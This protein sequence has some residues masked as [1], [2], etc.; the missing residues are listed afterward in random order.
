MFKFVGF[1][2][3]SL[4]LSSCSADNDSIPRVTP[5]LIEKVTTDSHKNALI[6]QIN[7][8]FNQG[9]AIVGAIPS[10]T[11]IDSISISHDLKD[12]CQWRFIQLNTLSCDLKT[13]LMY[14]A[15]YHIT[16]DSTFNALGHSLSQTFNKIIATQAPI[17]NLHRIPNGDKLSIS[18]YIENFE[19]IDIPSLTLERYL[20]LKSPT[21][22]FYPVSVNKEKRYNRERLKITI[23]DLPEFKEDGRYEFVLPVGFQA[24]KKQ[25][26]LT[27]EYIV[28]SFRH[29]NQLTFYG[30]SCLLSSYPFEYKTIVINDQGVL[31]CAPERI[32]LVFSSKF[33]QIEGI[34]SS[35][36]L[37]WIKGK[38]MSFQHLRYRGDDLH[39][40]IEF[41]GNTEYE[42]D[43]TKLKN[44]QGNIKKPQI[45]IFK[46]QSSTPLWG[47]TDFNETVVESQF[48]ALPQLVR[49][50]VSQLTQETTPINTSQELL[51]F[52]NKKS[53][54]IATTE[55]LIE[56]PN[57]K[58]KLTKQPIP[59][60]QKLKSLSGL[61]HIKLT[62]SSNTPIRQ[63]KGVISKSDSF[64]ANSAAFNMAIWHQQ[65][66]MIQLIDWDGNFVESGDITLVCK[67]QESPLFLGKTESNG[68]LWIKDKAWQKIYSDFR[69][70]ECW[71]WAEKGT[72]TAAIEIPAVNLKLSDSIKAMAWSTQPIYQRGDLV[73]IGFI[74]RKRT[75][76]G[77]TPLTSLKNY[78][79]EL[80]DP[81]GSSIPIILSTP[82]DMGFT[83]GSYQLTNDMPQGKY[84]F[85]L[86]D[87][88]LGRISNV[89]EFIV[90]EFIAPEF[91]HS[92]KAPSKL[93]IDKPIEISI[94][95]KRMN[96]VAL[97]SA[98]ANI[99]FNISRNYSSPLNWP[100]D[101]DFDTWEDFNKNKN[102]LEEGSS[103]S[104]S[105]DIQGK[106]IVNL[107]DYQSTIPYGRMTINSEIIAD[108]GAT[109]TASTSRPYFAR[110]HYIGTKYNTEKQQLE[111]IAIDSQ[112]N[113]INDINV[114]VNI[115]LPNHKDKTVTKITSCQFDTLPAHCKVKDGD[116]PLTVNISSGDD[117]YQWYR[118]ID[119]KQ[120]DELSIIDV[121]NTLE[122]T[123]VDKEIISDEEFNV[124]LTSPFN[125]IATFIINGD[126]IKK[127]WQQPVKKGAN[128]I[129][130]KADKS[131]LPSIRLFAALSVSR[132]VANAAIKQQLSML[133]Q[134]NELRPEVRNNKIYALGSQRLLTDDIVIYSSPTTISPQVKLSVSQDTV[135]A[136]QTVNLT[137]NSEQNSQAQLW[138]VNDALLALTD[139]KLNRYNFNEIIKRHGYN[140][141]YMSY[142]ALSEH[143]VIDAQLGLTS[144]DGDITANQ[145]FRFKEESGM[146]FDI[147]GVS[148]GDVSAMPP[149]PLLKPKDKYQLADSRLLALVDLKKGESQ[150]LNIELPQL[151]GRWKVVALTA[152]NKSASISTIDI[153]TT[154][155]VEYFIDAP[156]HLYSEDVSQLAVT[157]INQS[158]NE[159]T[160]TLILWSDDKPLTTLDVHLKLKQQKRL[161]I[162][163][164]NLPVGKHILRLTSNR[165]ANYVNYHEINIK[166]TLF[167]YQKKWLMN[168]GQKEV[169]AKPKYAI[170]DSIKLRYKTLHNTSPDWQALATYNK[171]Y[172]H[173]CWEQTISRALSFSVNPQAN[174]IWPSGGKIL[175][176][177]LNENEQSSFFSYFNNTQSDQFLMAY[178]YLVDGWLN[179]DKFNIQIERKK[180]VVLLHFFITGEELHRP[181]TN[182]ERSMALLAL[183]T[184]NDITLDEAL[185]YRQ[186]IGLADPFSSVLQSLA[187]KEL[188]ADKTLYQTQLLEFNDTT[189]QD[190]TTNLF[191]QTS[192]QCFA[193]LVYDENSIERE[194]LTARVIAKQQELGHF[195]STFANGVCGYLLKDKRVVNH[196]PSHE[197]PYRISDENLTYTIKG[198]PA[199][200]LT[201][202]Y[203]EPLDA[204]VK[205]SNGINIKRERLLRVNDKWQPILDTTTL[206]V[207][208]IVKT[209]LSVNSAIKREHIVVTDSVAGGLEV[210]S[211]FLKNTFYHK[212]NNYDWRRRNHIEIDDDKVKW[213]II[214]LS[215]DGQEYAYYS[216]VRHQGT[217]LT[218]PASAQAMYRT[219]I[220]ART[221]SSLITIK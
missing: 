193:A 206:E 185:A 38:G 132:E 84:R 32:S 136:G 178:T 149:P 213:Y 7:I 159:L 146:S 6:K 36:K 218:G 75:Q 114:S 95:A 98:K 158:N 176:N 129:Q 86:V 64:I 76:Q 105:L 120:V 3:A 20:K 49:R 183:A 173:Q 141:N 150:D 89:G 152:T 67:D 11:Q 148:L 171:N 8:K 140:D 61:A 186:K 110:K 74:A 41:D 42:I 30:F 5:L 182:Q 123:R 219:D 191:N 151:I 2:I 16:V 19:N 204:A 125:G 198:Q 81:N 113:E 45:I 154:R 156:D 212:D 116:S 109:Q 40:S 194:Q 101:Y 12:Q 73:E 106:L 53:S 52:L 134:S 54:L 209:V 65:D 97:T 80:T 51:S 131:W 142:K 200:W 161:V 90:T 58:H 162:N 184:H 144:L 139:K 172:P 27:Q 92:V 112:G 83:K 48:Q 164:P 15:D 207:G 181:I 215:Q 68:M 28:N 9:V 138:L 25:R 14:M 180:L 88:I 104:H 108:D 167:D 214:N 39:L 187:L 59:F 78:H 130:L 63:N 160:D 18:S 143:L 135:L 37:N 79:L 192:H 115:T 100:K 102:N 210:I 201:L 155:P 70:S 94:Q 23:Q 147:G 168:T 1:I 72:L 163:L 71:L 34:E 196:L 96:G 24:S 169:I 190:E 47:R 93:F 57:A 195:G 122:L 10:K 157:A 126:T 128:V 145:S 170:K 13:R 133:D 55:D 69:K 166:P 46:T 91:E 137:I 118:R 4:L 124:T 202:D 205:Q 87:D 197:L 26:I 22:K 211:P 21:G 208:D 188:G 33:E 153:T 121:K 77:L 66:L 43:L 220:N 44:H 29:S 174:D 127:T 175:Q 17:L 119:N 216:R 31:P 103:L 199:H 189:Y 217:F 35:S 50:N 221:A 179:S 117:D 165:D 62:G 177:K 111:I 60:R 99:N 107:Q 56:A 85:K 82:S 203:Q